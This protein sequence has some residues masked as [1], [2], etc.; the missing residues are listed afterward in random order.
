LSKNDDIIRRAAICMKSRAEPRRDI[1]VERTH[2]IV[3]EEKSG[4]EYVD[5]SCGNY[6]VL[7][8]CHPEIVK[9]IVEVAGRLDHVPLARGVTELVVEHAEKL[10]SIS[11]GLSDGKVAYGC[12]GTESVEF[13]TKLAVGHTR[14]PILIAYMGGHYGRGPATT[15]LTADIAASKSDYPY[16]TNVVHVPFPYCYRCPFGRGAS[17]CSLECFDYLQGTLDTVVPPDSVAGIL[18]EAIQ[19]W[20]G[21]VVPPAEYMRRLDK[22]CREFGI[23]LIDD[24]V[25]LNMGSTGRMLSIEHFEVKPS[26]I[27]LGKALGFGFPLSAIVAS[28]KMID[29]W[30]HWRNVSTA[31]ANHLAIAASIKGMEIIERDK[32]LESATIIGSRIREDIQKASTKCQHVGDVRGKGLCIG[33]EFVQDRE[34]KKPAPASAERFV[35]QAHERGLLLGRAGTYRHVVRISPPLITTRDIAEKAEQIISASL[36]AL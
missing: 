17:G 34:S 9:T 3:I 15:G 12:S 8:Y 24:E 16:I 35:E 22:L 25:L 33:V 27:A 21:Y 1:A 30:P 29:Q 4:K 28:A 2:G 26:V 31:A 32:L 7:G 23:L 14:R 5:F 11:P 20:N 19:G 36:D 6:N 18:I 13:A 10:R